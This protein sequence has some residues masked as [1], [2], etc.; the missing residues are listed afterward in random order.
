M[1]LKGGGGGGGGILGTDVSG[2]SARSC[3]GETGTKLARAGGPIENHDLFCSTRG[4]GGGEVMPYMCRTETCRRSGYTF[5]PS[6]PR[7]GVFFRA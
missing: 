7:Q 6:N 2:T 1:V 5:W 4:G 3:S